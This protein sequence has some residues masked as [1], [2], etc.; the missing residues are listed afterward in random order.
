M[1]HAVVGCADRYSSAGPALAPLSLHPPHPQR[2]PAHCTLHPLRK[3]RLTTAPLWLLE[4]S[5]YEAG[6]SQP[7][8]KGAP[9]TRVDTVLECSTRTGTC[10]CA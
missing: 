9:N 7:T 4:A 10:L 6:E 1:S 8:S 5:V 3:A 2:G